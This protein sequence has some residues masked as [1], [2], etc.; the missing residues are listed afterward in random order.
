M[1]D[2]STSIA[3]NAIVLIRQP[4]IRPLVDI[5]YSAGLAQVN[6]DSEL[7]RRVLASDDAVGSMSTASYHELISFYGK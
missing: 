1:G 4:V 6:R 3:Q 2:L 7:A 5:P